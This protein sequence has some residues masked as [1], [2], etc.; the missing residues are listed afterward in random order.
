MIFW[1]LTKVSNFQKKSFT[2]VTK[3]QKQHQTKN[4]QKYNQNRQTFQFSKTFHANIKKI[5]I[6]IDKKID[7][8]NPFRNTNKNIKL[9]PNVA[10]AILSPEI[11]L[12][13]SI[14]DKYIE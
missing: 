12:I 9:K 6:I 10:N 3:I 8:L 1:K 5:P 11:K 14:E 2:L 7:F 4:N 13:K